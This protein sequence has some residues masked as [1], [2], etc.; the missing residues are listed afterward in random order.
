MGGGA[1]YMLHLDKSLL[2]FTTKFKLIGLPD[3]IQQ[4]S[5]RSDPIWPYTV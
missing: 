5:I 2:S 4:D 3:I 1:L